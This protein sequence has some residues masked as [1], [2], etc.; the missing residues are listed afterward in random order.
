MLQAKLSKEQIEE[1]R[2]WISISGVIEDLY[3]TLF[4]AEVNYGVSSSEYAKVLDKLRLS[5]ETERDIEKKFFT[6]ETLVPLLRYFPEFSDNQRLLSKLYNDYD[7]GLTMKKFHRNKRAD[8]FKLFGVDFSKANEYEG[9]SEFLKKFSSS[10]S[11]YICDYS[12][13][14]LEFKSMISL[15]DK[16]I[17]ATDDKELKAMLIAEKN[18]IICNSSILEDEYFLLGNVSPL[19]LDDEEFVSKI[20]GVSLDDYKASKELYFLVETDETMQ[21]IS[22]EVSLDDESRLYYELKFENLFNNIGDEAKVNEI[23]DDLEEPLSSLASNMI[24][25]ALIKSFVSSSYKKNK[26]K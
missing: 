7:A 6:D 16:K 10:D 1:V 20:A 19:L 5:L 9:D 25:E 2:T 8:L 17:D 26:K 12:F 23:I 11:E 18:Q 15:I 4:L 22:D 3:D 13:Q 21:S 24:D 14:Y